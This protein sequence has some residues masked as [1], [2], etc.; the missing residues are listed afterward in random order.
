MNESIN[1][2]HQK[3][4]KFLSYLKRLFRFTKKNNF[5]LTDLKS[6]SIS[7]FYL[8]LIFISLINIIL[9]ANTKDKNYK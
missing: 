9:Y 8:I 4:A 7:I 5:Q 6:N 2:T 3:R 1:N